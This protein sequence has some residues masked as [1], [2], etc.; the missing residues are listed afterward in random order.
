MVGVSAV[1]GEIATAYRMPLDTGVTD[2]FACDD[3]QT[4]ELHRAER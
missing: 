2:R 1:L 4:I 3:P